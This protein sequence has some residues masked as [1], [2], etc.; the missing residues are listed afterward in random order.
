MFAREDA[1][2]DIPHFNS[3]EEWE[4][5]KSTKLDTAAQL[6]QYLLQQDDLPNPTFSN[7]RVHFPPVSLLN[8]DAAKHDLKIV[9]FTEFPS[10]ISL[11]QNVSSHIVIGT[12]AD[13]CKL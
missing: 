8:E 11:F 7:G 10:M 3:L 12:S 9:V 4:A 13:A 5:V 2:D 1:E 6:C